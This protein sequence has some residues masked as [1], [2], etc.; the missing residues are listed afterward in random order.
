MII[1]FSKQIHVFDLRPRR[2]GN[3]EAVLQS[4]LWILYPDRRA[5][6]ASAGQSLDFRHSPEPPP[7]PINVSHIGYSQQKAT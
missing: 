7:R 5:G 1:S 2:R 3:V 4:H 6:P